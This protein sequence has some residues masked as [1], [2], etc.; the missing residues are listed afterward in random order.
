M[1]HH[2]ERPEAHLAWEFRGFWASQKEVTVTLAAPPAMIQTVVG[3]VS[4]VAATG[5]F[6]VVD[7]WTVPTYVVLRVARATVEDRDVYEQ[8]QKRIAAEEEAARRKTLAR[9][10]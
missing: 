1:S 9:I 7:G 8:E 2:P 4:S 5:A 10:R 6:A 3:R